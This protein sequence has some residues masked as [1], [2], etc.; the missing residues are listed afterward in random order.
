MSAL[1]AASATLVQLWKEIWLPI[2]ARFGAWQP[3]TL[4]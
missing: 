4:A 3:L 2:A 1:V